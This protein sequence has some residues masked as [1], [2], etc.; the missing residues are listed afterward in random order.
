MFISSLIKRTV[1]RC[2]QFLSGI[3]VQQISRVGQLSD[4]L[5]WQMTT[6]ICKPPC[7]CFRQ[8]SCTCVTAFRTANSFICR[9]DDD[10]DDSET[11]GKGFPLHKIYDFS[12]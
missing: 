1:I 8:F 3:P 11:S 12:V 4:G 5:R 6:L 10:D 2:P 7:S 9:A